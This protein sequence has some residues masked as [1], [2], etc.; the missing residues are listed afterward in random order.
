MIRKELNKSVKSLKEN[1]KVNFL[2]NH[3]S[4]EDDEWKGLQ[5]QNEALCINIA[6]SFS[7]IGSPEYALKRL[8]INHNIF[9]QE[10]QES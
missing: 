8:K 5:A 7:G 2:I 6:T 3:S 9:L 1:D 10:T 4:D